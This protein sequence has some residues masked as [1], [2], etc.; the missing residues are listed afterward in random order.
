MVGNVINQ[1]ISSNLTWHFML[2]KQRNILTLSAFV[3]K[4]R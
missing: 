3:V 4:G 2:D 1:I